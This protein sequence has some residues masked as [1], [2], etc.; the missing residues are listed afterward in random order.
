MALTP[1]GSPQWRLLTAGFAKNS[2][3]LAQSAATTS[4]ELKNVITDET[5]SGALVFATSPTLVTPALGTPSSVTLN[6]RDRV[7][8]LD[9]R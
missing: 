1:Y 8:D 6:Q 3:T 4:L 9:R 7:A 5:G 2:L